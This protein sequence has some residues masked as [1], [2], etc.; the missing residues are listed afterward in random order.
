MKL[1]SHN[2]GMGRL[3]H[4][5]IP[6]YYLVSR[7]N[8]VLSKENTKLCEEPAVWNPLSTTLPHTADHIPS[9]SLIGWWPTR[10]VMWLA[11]GQSNRSLQ[12]LVCSRFSVCAG[13]RVM[14]PDRW[15][16]PS[17]DGVCLSFHQTHSCKALGVS[18]TE[19]MWY[20]FQLVLRLHCKSY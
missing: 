11:E 10:R 18:R 4:V 19:K 20:L 5:K 13:R 1:G 7:S 3:R 9:C 16:R 17:A 14:L 6:G 12:K 2:E 15:Q 8:N